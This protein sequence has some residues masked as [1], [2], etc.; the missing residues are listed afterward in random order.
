[1]SEVSVRRPAGGRAARLL[2][3]AAA[4]EEQD[5]VLRARLAVAVPLPEVL[6]RRLDAAARLVVERA[7]L[8]REV[9]KHVLAAPPQLPLSLLEVVVAQAAEEVGEDRD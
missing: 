1:M 4:H 8:V 2:V 5:G 3:I 9:A 6:E 7:A